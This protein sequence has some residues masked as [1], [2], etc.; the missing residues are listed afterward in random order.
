MA[1][2]F[3]WILDTH[4]LKE[5]RKAESGTTLLWMYGGPGTGKTML[6]C[7]IL[8]ELR[9]H[10]GAG[11]NL[12]WVFCERG[13]QR[14]SSAEAA[15]RA[16]LSM[17]A[18]GPLRRFVTKHIQAK[19]DH[20]GP[21]MFEDLSAWWTLREIFMKATEERAKE[22]AK[23]MAKDGQGGRETT[24]YLVVDALDECETGLDN[25]LDLIASTASSAA[26][27][28][29]WLVTSHVRSRIRRGLWIGQAGPGIGMDLDD[30][31][32]ETSGAVDAY[33]Q[34]CAAELS[35]TEDEGDEVYRHIRAGLEKKKGNGTF[36]HVALAA[37]ALRAV[38]RGQ[39]VGELKRLSVDVKGLYRQAEE[40]IR[41]LGEK[42]GLFKCCQRALS[43]VAVACR[44][45][46]QHELWL[47]ADLGPLTKEQAKTVVRL[48]ESF[49]I[50]ANDTANFVHESARAYLQQDSALLAP[51]L[52]REHHRLF[53]TCLEAMESVLRRDM[54]ESSHHGHQR[55]GTG[56][57][58][59]ERLAAAEYACIYWIEHLVVSGQ[60]DHET[61]DGGALS[62][63]LETRFL[64]WLEYLALHGHMGEAI[65]SWEKL[66]GFL[67]VRAVNHQHGVHLPE[68]ICL[69]LFL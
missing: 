49:F 61:R 62:A 35:E 68:A 42:E 64:F 6:V 19:Y 36:L 17:L 4:D 67:K 9:K 8:D 12:A 21:A 34:Q 20:A 58:D 57:H 31:A 28:V 24:Y 33:V 1:D 26:V 52:K 63:F 30:Y 66:V 18:T 10:E 69:L 59:K 54:R 56:D 46:R 27:R 43:A 7:G 38:E 13:N 47:L 50:V 22:M 45:L 55:P 16:L 40:R 29:K 23:E 14:T 51:S 65:S 11:G 25:L 32:A 60:H 3:R 2:A 53:A 39:R 41:N 48:C 37:R 5:W 15:L 44:P